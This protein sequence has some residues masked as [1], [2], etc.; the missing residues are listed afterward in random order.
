MVCSINFWNKG[1]SKGNETVV[2]RG[3]PGLGA[4]HGSDNPGLWLLRSEPL[5]LVP[6]LGRAAAPEALTGLH[7]GPGQRESPGSENPGPTENAPRQG[8]N[9]VHNP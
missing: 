5:C 4:L 1:G 7:G 8:G 9:Q 3:S 6:S 2:T